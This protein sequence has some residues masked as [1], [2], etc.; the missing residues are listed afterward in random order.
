M[1]IYLA[2]E[3]EC[4]EI[5]LVFRDLTCSKSIHDIQRSP[6]FDRRGAEK[7]YFNGLGVAMQHSEHSV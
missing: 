1:Q 2:P 6:L 5:R 3:V 4:F 7:I